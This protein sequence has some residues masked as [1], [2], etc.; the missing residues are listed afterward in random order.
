MS[1]LHRVIIGPEMHEEQ[2]RLLIQHVAVQS[3]HL[4]SV[5]SQCL[6]HRIDLLGQ[7]HEV[8]GDGSPP[9]AGWLIN[10]KPR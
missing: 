1:Q 6:Q 10:S 7:K 8:A 5:V 3:G 4:D 9:V 2:S